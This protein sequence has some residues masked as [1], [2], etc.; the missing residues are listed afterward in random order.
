MTSQKQRMLRGESYRADDPELAAER[1]RCRLLVERLNAASVADGASIASILGELLGAFG[2]G[3]Y[4]TPPLYCDYGYNIAIGARTFVNFGTIIL[5]CAPVTI[6]DDVQ[7][8]PGVQLLTATHPVAAAARQEGWESAAPIDIG[9]GAW[10]GGGVIVCPGVSIGAEAVVGAGS[11]V[12]R[13]VP[14]GQLAVGNPCRV[15][16]AL[17]PEG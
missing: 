17:G 15:V 6:G 7:I 3:A 9:D 16:R 2:E 14:A 13:D 10:L 4:V 5:D 8:A 12:T 11:V 1:H